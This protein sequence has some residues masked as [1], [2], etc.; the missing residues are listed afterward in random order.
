MSAV[1]DQLS[2][3]IYNQFID[4]V[5]EICFGSKFHIQGE[6][7]KKYQSWLELPLI[8]LKV[9]IRSALILSSNVVHSNFFTLSLQL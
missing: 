5:F 7:L 6:I 4:L 9:L 2:A 8:I 3:K 1:F